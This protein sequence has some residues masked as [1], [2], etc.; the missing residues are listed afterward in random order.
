MLPLDLIGKAE[1]TLSRVGQSKP[2][3]MSA[4]VARRA[5]PS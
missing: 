2:S 4:E 1:K 5:A 3:P